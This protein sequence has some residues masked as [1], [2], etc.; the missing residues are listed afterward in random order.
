MD[1]VFERKIFKKKL[2]FNSDEVFMTNASNFVM[3][4]V[5][6]DGKKI[7]QGKSGPI[8]LLLRNEYI[9]AI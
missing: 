7:A 2:L 1:F 5:K 9:K 4:I 6:I 8:S 3:P